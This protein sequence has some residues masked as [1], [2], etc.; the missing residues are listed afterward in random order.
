M[1]IVSYNC[2]GLKTGKN[3][4]HLRQTVEYL[5]DEFDVI[6]LQETWLNK[7]EQCSLN[8]MR[9]DFHG[10]GQCRSGD[11]R[12]LCFNVRGGV[13]IMWKSKYSSH[14][15]PIKYDEDW[16]VGI[17]FNDCSKRFVILCVYM[18]Y[19]KYDHEDEY[20]RKLGVLTAITQD[21]DHT[22]YTI[23]GDWNA[24]LVN[25]SLFSRHIRSFCDDTNLIISSMNR[26]PLDTFTY[27]SDATMGTSWIDH[28]CAVQILTQ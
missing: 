10:V 5:C 1:K 15:T 3:Q 20:I 8:C 11:E 13:A 26:L 16:I 27:V 21:L 4:T 14:V 28:V 22:C 9:D 17:E 12:K 7:Q 18:P 25:T 2:N 6:C 23:C 24:D 19:Q